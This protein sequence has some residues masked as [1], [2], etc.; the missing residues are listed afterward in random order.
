MSMALKYGL[1]KRSKKAH[2]GEMEK[3]CDEHG[4][5]MCKMCHGGEYAKGGDVKGVHH[6]TTVGYD[7]EGQSEAGEAVRYAKKDPEY[8]QDNKDYAKSKHREVLGEMHKM[9][10]HDR[11]YLADGGDVFDTPP[12]TNPNPVDK[13]MKKAF[14]TPGYAEGGE[15]D[16]DMVS[17]I[18]HKRKMMSEGGMAANDVGEGEYADEEP[19]QFDDLEKDDHLEEH[20]TGKNS[21]D[22]D[23]DHE[24]DEEMHDMISQIMKS[25]KKK[26]K[27]PRPA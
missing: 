5:A 22:E 3:P 13:S 16:D 19:N 26:D 7:R 17:H 12:E 6:Q 2:G 15:M 11:K 18:M 27:M 8:A 1:M 9:K 25:R 14:K 21:G 20:Y 24:H 4:T 10:G 23:G